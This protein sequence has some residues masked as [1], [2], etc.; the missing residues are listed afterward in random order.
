[1][2]SNRDKKIA[3][4]NANTLKE[5]HLITLA[6]NA[7]VILIIYF[8]SR[9]SS[10]LPYIIFSFPAFFSQYTLE[11]SGRP[12][13]GND[14]YGQHRLI[15]SGDEIKGEGL[16]EYMFDIIYVTWFL[17]ILMVA[18]GSNKVWWLFLA[19]PGYASYKLFGFVKPFL[20]LGK[21]SKA[22]GVPESDDTADK[23]GKKGQSK[24][25]AK[26]EARGQKQQVRYR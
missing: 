18:F 1:M 16:F 6:I 25:Q 13:Y 22:D 4:A 21:G 26:L 14:E 10:F 5:L 8:F 11:K 20:S 9:P 24:R 2:A 23:S 7:L 19:V 3:T 15:S 17:D 12:K